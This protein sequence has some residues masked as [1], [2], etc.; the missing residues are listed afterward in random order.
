MKTISK[1][2][3][4]LV[5]FDFVIENMLFE[6]NSVNFLAFIKRKLLVIAFLKDLLT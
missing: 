6:N 3:L 2:I 4:R 1:N 5:L